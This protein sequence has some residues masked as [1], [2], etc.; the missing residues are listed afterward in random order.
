MRLISNNADL[1]IKI[2]DV[3]KRADSETLILSQI[4]YKRTYVLLGTCAVAH[5]QCL[6]FDLL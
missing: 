1:S 2:G 3:L 5:C 6:N 4:K